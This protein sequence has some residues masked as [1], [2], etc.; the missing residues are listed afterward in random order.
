MAHIDNIQQETP[1]PKDGLSKRTP[2]R[3]EDEPR[4]GSPE[5][6]RQRPDERAVREEPGGVSEDKPIDGKIATPQ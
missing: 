2:H 6:D 5:D 1:F 4:T 3:K